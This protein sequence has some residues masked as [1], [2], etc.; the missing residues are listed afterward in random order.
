MVLPSGLAQ[1]KTRTLLP[2][3]TWYGGSASTFPLRAALRSADS[4]GQGSLLPTPDGHMGGDFQ[5]SYIHKPG[6]GEAFFHR[7]WAP[8]GRGS[9][10]CRSA[11]WPKK[12]LEA[13]WQDLTLPPGSSVTP[14][15]APVPRRS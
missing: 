7:E 14:N 8:S 15:S 9:E 1:M 4:R 10:S 5:R 2:V 12:G 3:G 11:Q 13:F 6:R